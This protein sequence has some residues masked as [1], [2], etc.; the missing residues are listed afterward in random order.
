MS[1]RGYKHDAEARD[2]IIDTHP[3]SAKLTALAKERGQSVFV[4]LESILRE[5]AARVGAPTLSHLTKHLTI[6]P[7]LHG[8]RSPLADSTMRGLFSG[9]KLDRGL[10]DLATRYYATLEAIALQTEYQDNWVLGQGGG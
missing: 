10:V 2:F 3:A 7:D 8:N 1:L 9:L 4:V 5:E 6:Y